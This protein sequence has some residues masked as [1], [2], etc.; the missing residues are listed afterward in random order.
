MSIFVWVRGLRGPSPQVWA[1]MTPKEFAG[2]ADRILAQHRL[3][4]EEER[5]SL[6][7]LAAKYPAPPQTE[8]E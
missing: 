5:L 3:T 4:A 7:E 1:E 8:E 2:R 6:E